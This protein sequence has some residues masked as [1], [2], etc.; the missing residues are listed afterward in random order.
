[1]LYKKDKFRTKMP[2]LLTGYGAYGDTIEPDFNKFIVSLLDRGFI[3]CIAH[4][5]GSGFNNHT[6]WKKGKKLNKKNTFIDF[7]NCAKFLIN[8]NYTL[9]DRLN[10]FGRSAGGL[11]IGAV[12]NMNPE[13]FNLAI[14]GVPF[15]D[16]ITDMTNPCTPLTT[17][18]Y[19]EW[20]NPN[21]KK[22]LKYISSYSPIDN[23]NFNHNY[24]NLYIYTNKNDTLVPYDGVI[25]YF[26][27]I[28][29]SKVFKDKDKDAFIYVNNKYG[30]NQSSDKYEY[31]EEM[32]KLYSI[33]IQK[34]QNFI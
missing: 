25:R 26:N 18:E 4:V 28:S 19:E 15:V 31:W 12:L 24:P 3:Y 13:L 16:V 30:H 17:E 23:I 21:N 20:G 2:C 9:P 32:S 5:R 10:I 1:M 7:I 29:S 34:N 33:I 27:K 6:W 8:N 14:M 11:L 22:V